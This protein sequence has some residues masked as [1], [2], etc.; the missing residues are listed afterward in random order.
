[1][2]AE[3][4]NVIVVD[5]SVGASSVNYRTVIANTLSSGAA[6][7]N[8]IDWLNQ[9]TGS[10]PVQYHIVGHGFG[11]HQAGIVGRNVQGDI[12][13]ITGGIFSTEY[14]SIRFVLQIILSFDC[15]LKGDIVEFN[16]NFKKN[17][18]D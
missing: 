9:V 1:M 7:A 14:C 5:W 6:V 15:P 12:T 11:A 17:F 8:F 13:Y 2:A 3:D 18:Q 10:S 4:V 16:G